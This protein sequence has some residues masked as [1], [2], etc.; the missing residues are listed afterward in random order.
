M[1]P[2]SSSDMTRVLN[3]VAGGNAGARIRLLEMIYDEL[4]RL[5]GGLMLGER[6]DHTLQ[7]TALIHEAYLRLLGTQ[8]SSWANRAHFFGAAAEVMRRILIDH[9][10]KRCAGKRG[11][12]NSQQALDPDLSAQFENPAELLD[13]DEALTALELVEPR[14]AKVVKLRFFAGLGMD[15]IAAVLNV[16]TI[17]AKRDWRFARAWLAARMGDR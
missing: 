12:D 14:K 1:P 5:A 13:V 3:D 2:S 16:S 17:T 8:T 6:A 7:P 10:R 4:H 11:G 15:E 9:A